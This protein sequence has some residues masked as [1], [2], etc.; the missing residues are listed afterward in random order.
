MLLM[1][2]IECHL[3]FLVINF[4]ESFDLNVSQMQVSYYCLLFLIMFIIFLYINSFS[5][6]D[7]IMFMF[8]LIRFLLDL[9]KMS[10]DYDEKVFGWIFFVVEKFV[11]CVRILM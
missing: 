10:M 1:L 7:M 3:I 2:L 5:L 6:N 8:I 9:N 4:I 11:A